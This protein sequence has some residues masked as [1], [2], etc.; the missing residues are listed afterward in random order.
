MAFNNAIRNLI[1]TQG[2][3]GEELLD[4]LD[5]IESFGGE[6]LTNNYLANRSKQR[7]KVYEYSRV[8]KVAL[9]NW[10]SGVAKGLIKHGVDNGLDAWRKLYYKYVPLAEDLQN[11]LIQELMNVQIVTEADVDQIFVDI[12]RIRDLYTKAGTDEDDSSDRWIRAAVLRKLQDFILK[13]HA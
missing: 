4:V 2:H 8:I 11:L 10:T 1:L 9:M 12:E 6:K 3:D 13:L 7:H 5:H